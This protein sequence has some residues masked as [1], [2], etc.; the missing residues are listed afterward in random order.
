MKREKTTINGIVQGVGFRPFVYRLAKELELSGYVS[1]NS[2][3]VV[4]EIEGKEIQLEEFHHHLKSEPP[5]LSKITDYT[6]DEIPLC[7]D[8]AFVIKKSSD[9][10]NPSTLISPDISTCDDCLHELFDK[11]D[12]RYL[13]PFINCTNCGPRFTIV[14]GIPY[15][16]HMTSMS[17][18]PLCSKCQAEYDNP[19]N[20]RFHAQPNACPICG[21]KLTL[22][23][24]A[25]EIN[26]NNPIADVIDL[27]HSGNIVAVKGIGGFHLTVDP[28]NSKAIELLRIRK[29]RAEKPFALM[30]KDIQTIQKY[31]EVTEKEIDLLE[32]YQRPIILLRKKENCTLPENI[33]PNNQYL[34]F[35]LAY[36]PIHHLLLQNE[37]D[38]LIM[39][40]ANISEEPIV[41]DNDDAVKRL[42]NIADYFLIHDRDI[43]Q[44]CDDSIVRISAGKKQIIR[45]ARG[46]VPYPVFLNKKINQGILAVGG[47]LK[48][49][50]AISR[51]DSVFQSQ[52]IGD[53]DNPEAFSFFEHSISHL[54]KIMQIE[55]AYIAYDMHPE[56][57]STKWAKKQNLPTIAVQHHHAHMVSVMAENN[58]Y[59]KT[60]GI[61][62][63][64][65]GYGTDGTIWGGEVLVGDSTKFN[66]FSSLKH[67]PLPGGT[68][69]I[70]E[71]WR[72]ALSYLYTIYEKNIPQNLPF[73]QSLD[74]EKSKIVCEMID[75]KFNSPLSSSCGRLFDAVSALLNIRQT[76][77]YDAQAAIELE[78]IASK[79][80]VQ[81]VRIINPSSGIINSSELIH[82][83]VGMLEQNKPTEDIALYFHYQLAEYFIAS[84]LAA[85]KKYSI[86]TVAL[87]GGVYQNKIFFEY[88]YNRLLNEKFKVLIH[89]ELPTNDGGI[90][91]GQI[92]IADAI[93]SEK[94]GRNIK[95]V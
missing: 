67:F 8:T 76:V 16:R 93:I 43:L 68:S 63:D 51:G 27:L 60:I 59:D 2:H 32:S 31:C 50:I 83:I 78:M 92:V 30:A 28:H 49:S 5:P 13:Y 72:M 66:R 62:L 6:I 61:I 39:T 38:S 45:R 44:R 71:P 33:S 86:Q 24:G 57:L 70:K 34:G 40:S 94:S 12:R 23:N 88:I 37:F 14:K 25:S 41:I 53:L 91:L 17:S 74:T 65:T 10:S 36:T 64:G 26:S 18:F 80:N 47:E 95:C 35:M 46:Y 48:N 7:Y 79:G 73:M 22:H 89:K 4:V 82:T 75:K 19:S 42:S 11:H 77:T 56:Y 52:Y 81:P 69:A 29:G 9:Y 90:A 85:R 21:P 87:S 15:D 3:G 1:N 54:S 84:A 58:Y 55:P 20:R